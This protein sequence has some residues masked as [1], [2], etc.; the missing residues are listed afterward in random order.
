[1]SLSATPAESPVEKM[2]MNFT[3]ERTAVRTA[4]KTGNLQ[5]FSTVGLTTSAERDCYTFEIFAADSDV[6]RTACYYH[7]KRTSVG[8]KEETTW[9]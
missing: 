3:V 5:S 1:M 2:R 7:Y 6:I 9:S 8:L 4:E